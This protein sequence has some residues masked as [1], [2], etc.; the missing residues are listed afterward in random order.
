MPKR[1]IPK[2]DLK[3]RE[4]F[5]PRFYLKPNVKSNRTAPRG[6]RAE[7]LISIL[8]RL[9]KSAVAMMEKELGCGKNEGD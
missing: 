4:I 2:K 7:I 1:A 8:Y 5:T 3:K 6:N 9:L